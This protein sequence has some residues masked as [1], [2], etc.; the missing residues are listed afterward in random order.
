MR[1]KRWSW[2]AGWGWAALLVAAGSMLRIAVPG[3]A[4][5][6]PHPR[7]GACPPDQGG[8]AAALY[9]ALSA[10]A[11][12]DLQG[13]R[14]WV[15]EAAHRLDAEIDAASSSR[16]WPR[17]NAPQLLQ[18]LAL[19]A[20]HARGLRPDLDRAYDDLVPLLEWIDIAN[21][22]PDRPGRLGGMRVDY[23]LIHHVVDDLGGTRVGYDLIY[24]Q[25]DRIADYRI[26]YDLIRRV[27]RRIGPIE[28]DYDLIHGNVERVAGL[29]LH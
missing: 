12:G 6:S 14:T 15:D 2:K 10:H 17:G 16:R 23:D 18:A 4:G 22:A 24:G 20:R 9:A 5:G 7:W 29:D 3:T 21:S 28:F 19:Y 25:I 8:I 26:D 1:A 27:P 11:G 13:A